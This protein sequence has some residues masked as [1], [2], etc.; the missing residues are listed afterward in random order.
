MMYSH[1]KQFVGDMDLG[2]ACAALGVSRG[3]Y[4]AWL[5]CQPQPDPFE[6]ALR[7]E[8]QGIA[9]EFPRYGYRRMAKELQRRD[10]AVNHKRVLA[11]MRKDNLLCVKKV[12]RPC[13]TD[14]NHPYR[15]YPNLAKGLV[16]TGLNQ[17]WVADI[18]YVRLPTEFIY[19][20]AIIDVFSR[21]CIGWGLGRGIDTS[22]TLTALDRAFAC[23]SG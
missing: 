15:I 8:I 19:L 9:L 10:F 16:V 6:M 23:R 2:S 18:T 17:L 13:T 4:R 12:F 20:A 7:S 5:A 22:L 1:I 11:L 14:S 21:R 3:R